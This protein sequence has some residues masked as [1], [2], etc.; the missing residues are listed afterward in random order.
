VEQN[1]ADPFSLAKRSGRGCVIVSGGIGHC[2]AEHNRRVEY[3]LFKSEHGQQGTLRRTVQGGA[4]EIG[5]TAFSL[6]EDV[7]HLAVS[8]AGGL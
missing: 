5:T 8:A 3:R 7:L 4:E 1:A 6:I 2:D